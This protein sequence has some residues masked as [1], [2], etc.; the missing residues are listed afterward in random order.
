MG[1]L[2][3]GELL[4]IVGSSGQGKSHI[5]NNFGVVATDYAQGQWIAHA[6]LEL[7]ELDNHLRYGA[8]ILNISMDDI[9]LNTP[10]FINNCSRLVAR[11]QIFV[12][13]FPPGQTHMGHL[14]SWISSLSADLGVGPCMILIDYPDLM[15]P[16]KGETDS[17]Y[18]NN[19]KIYNEIAALLVDYQAV[20]VVSSQLDRMHQNSNN[21][22]A[23]HMAN[24]IAKLYNADVVGT[25]NQTE[26]DATN[27]IGRLWW[28][29]VRRGRGKFFSHYRIDYARS[30]VWEDDSIANMVQ[31]GTPRQDRTQQQ[32]S[33]QQ[34]ATAVPPYANVPDPFAPS[35]TF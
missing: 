13:W 1:G 18:I 24:S 33:R 22:R 10:E 29:K 25:I 28:D 35:P 17:L 3:P 12:K 30:M 34:V 6:T 20:G 19:A 21:A 11:N 2:S 4:V 9:V 23:S 14:R 7:S 26:E 27:G 16:S 32:Q 31:G 8:R 15:T 5:T